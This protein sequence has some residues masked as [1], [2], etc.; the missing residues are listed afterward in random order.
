MGKLSFSVM[1]W[2]GHSKVPYVIMLFC[3]LPTEPQSPWLRFLKSRTSALFM[4]IHVVTISQTLLLQVTVLSPFLSIS[5]IQVN[6]PL[7]WLPQVSCHNICSLTLC[8]LM[9]WEAVVF[10]YRHDSAEEHLSRKDPL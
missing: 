10:D 4:C 3:S 7:L 2:G 6:L 9:Q 1:Q 5:W 8:L